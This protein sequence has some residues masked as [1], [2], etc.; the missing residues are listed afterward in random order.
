MFSLLKI[1]AVEGRTTGQLAGYQAAGLGVSLGFA[2]VG[3][4]IT[5]ESLIKRRHKTIKSSTVC[6]CVT[7][8]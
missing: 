7:V 1:F 3:G 2:I 5:G 4:V 8:M 6:Q